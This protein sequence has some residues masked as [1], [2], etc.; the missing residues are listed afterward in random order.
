MSEECDSLDTIKATCICTCS[1]PRRVFNCISTRLESSYLPLFFECV[2]LQ[3]R[4]PAE[5]HHNG[6]LL[7]RDEA[8]HEDILPATVVTLKH[9]LSEGGVLVEGNLFVPGTHQ[10]VHNVA[11]V[12]GAGERNLQFK[13]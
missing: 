6:L 8:K 3:T 12:C 4:V 1:L 11:G 5:Q 9:G 10:V 2:L 13:H 7:G